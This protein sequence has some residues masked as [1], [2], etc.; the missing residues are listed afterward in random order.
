MI[1]PSLP[2]LFL[3]LDHVEIGLML[4]CAKECAISTLVDFLLSDTPTQRVLNLARDYWMAHPYFFVI[5][6]LIT[7]CLFDWAGLD[8]YDF[9]DKIVEN[10]YVRLF[11]SATFIWC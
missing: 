3:P 6:V 5:T 7:E 10:P 8:A 1:L 9:D 4:K 2:Q 11:D